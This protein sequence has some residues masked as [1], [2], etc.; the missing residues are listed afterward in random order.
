MNCKD[1]GLPLTIL[2]GP[3]AGQPLTPEHLREHSGLCCDCFDE[4]FGLPAGQRTRSRPE[5]RPASEKIK[6]AQAD[7]QRAVRKRLDERRKRS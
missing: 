4:G 7:T 3:N 1:C 6:K 2:A 5:S